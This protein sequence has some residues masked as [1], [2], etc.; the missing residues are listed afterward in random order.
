MEFAKVELAAIEKTLS[1][2]EVE[3]K[4]MVYLN[5]LELALVGGGHGEVCLG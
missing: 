3:V 5:E 1:A 4:E 2:K